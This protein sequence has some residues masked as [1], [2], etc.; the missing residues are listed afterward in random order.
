M[1]PVGADG[2]PWTSFGA[3]KGRLRHDLPV[4]VVLLFEPNPPKPA[5]CCGWL[6]FCPNPE[7]DIVADY[8]GDGCV[9]LQRGGISGDT[10]YKC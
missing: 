5:L 6:L 1:V 2:S 7:K 3:M 4:P 10:E 8:I 9:C